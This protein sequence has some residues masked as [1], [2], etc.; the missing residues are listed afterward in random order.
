MGGDELFYG[1]HLVPPPV[2]KPELHSFPL[3]QLPYDTDTT[4]MLQ[5]NEAGGWDLMRYG[6]H[7]RTLLCG[8]K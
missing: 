1:D 8:H 3:L 5:R 6:K 2:P 7:I 4:A